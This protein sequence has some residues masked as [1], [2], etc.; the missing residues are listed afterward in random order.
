MK[1]PLPYSKGLSKLFVPL[2][3]NIMK[4]ITL[5]LVTGFIHVSANTFS[6]PDEINLNL[7]NVPLT[8]VFEELSAHTHIK[9]LYR[10]ETIPENIVSIKANN[11]SLNMVLDK[12]LKGTDVSY[13][14]LSSDLVVIALKKFLEQEGS[15]ITGTIKDVEG[16]PLAG[17][18]II[19][20]GTTNG[21]ITDINGNYTIDVTDSKANLIFSYVGYITQ[22][23]PVSGKTV[24]DLV[25]EYDI[26]GMEEIVVV[27]YGTQ[28]KVTLTGSVSSIEGD[29]LMQSPTTNFTNTLAGRIP[30]LVTYTRDG[31]PGYDNTTI[32]IRGLNTLDRDANDGID[33]NAALVVVD[34]IANRSMDRLDPANIESVTVLKDASAAIYG[35]QAANGVILI[36]TK[37]GNTGKPKIT[38]NYNYGLS[39]P[40]VIPEMA[41]AA[42]YAA[43][44]NELDLYRERDLR[45]TDEDIELF[46]NGN[47]PWGHP[48]TDWFAETFKNWTPQN[49]YNAS[50]A[51][52]SEFL[53]YYVSLGSKFQDGIYKN[54]ATYFK[55]YNFRT[56]IDGKL[57]KHINLGFDVAGR[58][59]NRNFP[60]QGK[61]DIFRMLQRGKP[62]EPAYWPDGT[63]GPDIE[64]GFNPVVITTDAT[65][66]D[67]DK[68]YILETNLRLNVDIPWIKGLSFTSNVAFDKYIRNRRR[69]EKPWYLYTWDGT[70]DDN[71]DP[72]LNKGARG[73]SEPNLTQEMEDEQ[74][75][76]GNARIN[77]EHSFNLHN[78][79][80]M[81]GSERYVREKGYV[82]AYRRYFVSDKVDQM[83]AG[84]RDEMDN[85][86][87]TEQSAR[88]N[89]FGRV[90]YNYSKKYLLEFVWRY[91]ASYNFHKDSRWGFFPGIS[92]G[93]RIS[94]EDF[95]K[96]N[97]S[98]MNQF[99]IRA[100][101]GQ[102]GNDRIK[103]YQYLASY[104]YDESHFYVFGVDQESLL[105]NEERIPN[106]NVTWEVANQT[107]IGFDA[108]MLDGKIALEAD[109][110]H[111]LRTN[112]L[113]QR[114][115]SVPTSSGISSN[116]P[117]ENIGE[118]VNQGF[119]FMATY[120]Y[121]TGNTHFSISANGGYQH[122]EIKF[123]DETPGRPDYQQSTGKPIPND[124]GNPDGD[125]YYEAIGIFSDQ[126]AIDAYPHWANARPG[127]VI[128]KD[129]NNDGEI[130]GEDRV[131]IDKREFPRFS[132]GLSVNI[133]YKQFDLSIL[134]QGTAGA[135]RYIKTES[136]ELGNYLKEF[137]DERWTEENPNASGPRAFNRDEE[138]WINQKNTY[139]LRNAN[140]IRLKNLE[141]GYNTPANFNSKFNIAG[142]RIYINGLNL[143]TFD[144]LKIFDPETTNQAGT[145]YPL[146]RTLNAGVSLTF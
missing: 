143:L 118:V 28:R 50:V 6:Q 57:S 111:N 10:D 29:V 63:P 80:L 2:I 146:S 107:D 42:T 30:G 94:E 103:E 36:T 116:L 32:R 9:F 76:T 136:G 100:S 14:F 45:Y 23:I 56:N 16:N 93:W 71:G 49:S 47:D 61:G 129:V 39:Q 109:Y 126:P 84:G 82:D 141:L 68:R 52:G 121:A 54:S 97:I 128:F 134:F 22:K 59:E 132:G 35:A 5:L 122:N 114:E 66:Y 4:L 37:R 38:L 43:M 96:S 24:I 104:K 124:P 77:Y 123:W 98:F 7:K 127:D 119:D 33:A 18:N 81:V 1:N 53:K 131:R 17:V 15:I 92:A 60:T 73:P 105:L 135:A 51:G 25:M 130:T 65:G 62:T 58:Q 41:D 86:G 78:I 145:Y 40:T 69:F 90:N 26:A 89:Y 46:A 20:E 67:K 137:A 19:V 31:E 8:E 48:N 138:Y 75:I 142:L 34:G 70:V 91:D 27:G 133:G 117:D 140:Y 79:Q 106:P 3:L 115:A 74:K 112:I 108:Q 72:V 139:F 88:L 21:T 64:Y 101:W 11:A 120:R 87:K 13:K 144:S 85:G 110:F 12:V 99:K 83:F 102:T 95:W 44:L 55:Q 125:L 113:I